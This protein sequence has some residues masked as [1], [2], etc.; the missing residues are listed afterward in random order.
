MT[1]RYWWWLWGWS[2]LVPAIF[3]DVLDGLGDAV[4]LGVAYWWASVP[5]LIL[6][7]A[8]VAHWLGPVEGWLGWLE[9]LTVSMLLVVT[10]GIVLT[11]TVLIGAKLAVDL[12]WTW[13]LLGPFLAVFFGVLGK[14][15]FDDWRAKRRARRETG[16]RP[17]KRLVR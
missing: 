17:A 5:V 7:V 2:I 11:V 16:H 8:A 14:A 4:A 9:K 12:G 10:A 3:F 13:I 6:A 1:R 15:V